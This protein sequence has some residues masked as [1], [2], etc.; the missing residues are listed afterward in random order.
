MMFHGINKGDR[1]DRAEK[2]LELVGLSDRKN[3]FP[4]ELSGGQR[5]RVAIGRS[6]ANDPEV[7]LA[8]EPTGKLD[9]KTGRDIMELFKK[10]N[11][12]GKTIILVTHDTGLLDYAT[13]VLR[14]KDGRLEKAPKQDFLKGRGA[15][16]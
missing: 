9:S 14:M 13:K 16:K 10:L 6:L 15:K 12:E 3:H 8:D 1:I 11:K 4:N 7:I 5:Q 2:I